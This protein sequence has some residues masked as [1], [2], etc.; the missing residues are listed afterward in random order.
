MLPWS[1]RVGLWKAIKT[2]CYE[3]HYDFWGWNPLMLHPCNNFVSKGAG[4]GGYQQN[5]EKKACQ[6]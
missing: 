6:N 4:V 1:G 5:L 3:M 2:V